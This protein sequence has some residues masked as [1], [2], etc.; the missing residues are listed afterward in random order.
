MTCTGVIG[1]IDGSHIAIEAPLDRR[2][3]YNNQKMT[4]SRI[5]QGVCDSSKKFINCFAGFPGSCH[6]ARVL[7]N[8]TLYR[9]TEVDPRVFFPSDSYHIVG[10][11]AYP[12]LIWLLVPIKDIENLTHV[13]TRFNKRL[14]QTRIIIECA[15]A[16]LKGRFRRLKMVVAKLDAI[17]SIITAACVLHNLC[18]DNNDD[19]D[20]LIDLDDML[21]AQALPCGNCAFENERAKQKRNHI[22]NAL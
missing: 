15:F 13:Q 14:S 11:S 3:E 18:L 6:D 22:E 21:G 10:D 1:A 19:A 17:P 9:Q 16:L 4:H 5:L 8:S 7:R 2:D 12:L 20:D